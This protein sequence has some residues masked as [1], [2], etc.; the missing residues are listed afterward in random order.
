MDE[1]IDDSFLVTY[2][3]YI[4]EEID[5]V[6][7]DREKLVTR[8]IVGGPKLARDFNRACKNNEKYFMTNHEVLFNLL[9]VK[10][11]KTRPVLI[12]WT[13]DDKEVVIY[14]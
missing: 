12:V 13:D 7:A 2:E 11:P 14:P 9:L 3:L 1:Y 10:H 6:D 5:V 4:S 8:L